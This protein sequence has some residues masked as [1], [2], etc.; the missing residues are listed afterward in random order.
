[1]STSSPPAPGTVKLTVMCS[2]SGTNLQALMD[3]VAAERIPG[4]QIIRV[5]VN[6]KNAFAVKRAEQAG[7]PAD[8]FN[9]VKDGYH[10][11][12][13]KDPVVVAAARAKYD[14]DLAQRVL[15]DGPDMVVLAGWMHVFSESF[16][17][18]LEREG[19][20]VINLHP[21]LPGMWCLLPSL[22]PLPCRPGAF[23]GADSRC[24]QVRRCQRHQAGV[25]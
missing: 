6:R 20:P 10:K 21:A 18:P 5:L 14:A 15:R 22:P 12:G 19:V 24:R 11:A 16:L 25:E 1:M 2:G 7:I 23:R 3:A 17:K 8:Y 9:L 13:E 4:A